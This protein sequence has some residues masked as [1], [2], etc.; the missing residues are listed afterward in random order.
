MTNPYFD[1]KNFILYHGD[2][3]DILNQFESNK[4]DLIYV[5]PPYF[6]SNDGITCSSGKMVSVNKGDWDRSKGFEEDINFI[7]SW[8]KAC[9]RVLK[10]N[11]SIWVSGTL[12]NIYK[13]GYL[14]EKNDYD[15]INDLIMFK[16]NA[17][18]NL[19]CK[20]FTHSHEVVLW[21]RK[22]KESQHLFNYAKMKIW[23]DPKDKLKNKDKQMRSVWSIPLIPKAEK[24]YG[25]HP[26]QKPMELLNRI[27]SSSSNEGDWVLDPF[28][29]SGTTGIVCSILNRK[30]AGIDSNYEY[31]DLAIKR[32]KDNKKKGLLFSPETKNHLM[33]FI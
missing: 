5:D 13:V 7:D 26:T 24:E 8:L 3:L 28:V 9:K 32:F 16:P 19:S 20:Y 12:H 10:E 31:L 14:L 23:N 15:I 17:P 4:F 1:E 25:K 33:K 27:I 11:G 22:S 18:P 29:G 21:A 2:A 6:L 30:F